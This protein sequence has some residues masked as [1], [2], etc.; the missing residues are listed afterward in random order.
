MTPTK[1]V[2]ETIADWNLATEEDIIRGYQEMAADEE[3]EQEAFE[4]IES[5][6]GECL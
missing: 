1:P 3:R 5:G 6:V 2:F 4:W